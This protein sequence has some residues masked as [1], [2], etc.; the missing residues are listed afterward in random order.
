MSAQAIRHLCQCDPRWGD[1]IDKIGA[2]QFP[3][4]EPGEPY[5]ALL[6]TI[7]YQQLA[8]SAARAIWNR[9]IALFD[10]GTPSPEL[11]LK[12]TDAHLR[13]AGVSRG[14]V[15]S[16]RDISAKALAG[17]VPTSLLLAQMPDTDIYERLLQLRGVGPWTVD[18]L[19]I[20]TLCRQDIMPVTDYGVRKGFQILYRKRAL[21]TPKQVLK[22]TEKWRPY[23]S[24]ATL[25]LWKIV[26]F[27][28]T[29]KSLAK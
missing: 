6:R 10:D 24:M 21:P 11:F 22:N 20:F 9:V 1:W 13:G 5:V 18:M 3:V 27:E 26:E 15:L 8:G 16:M 17:H 19:M 14:K 25:Y 23:R 7:A 2:L 4:Q 28:K 12:L 29:T